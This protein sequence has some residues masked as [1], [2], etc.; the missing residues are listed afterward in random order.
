MLPKGCG[1]V[2]SA[3]AAACPLPGAAL[4]RSGSAAAAR[5]SRAG[6]RQLRCAAMDRQQQMDRAPP[7]GAAQQQV[8]VE[9]HLECFGTGMEVECR[10]VQ[11]GPPHVPVPGEDPAVVSSS[12]SA[13]AAAQ[14]HT[15]EQEKG[16]LEVALDAALLVSPFFFWG[17]SMVAMKQLAPHTTPLLV[18][19]WRL[20]PAGA[21]LLLWARQS[22]RQTPTDPMA[23]VAMALFGLV[24]GACF[25]GF[26]VEGLQRTSA[27]L[28]S[29]IIDSQPLTVALLASLLFGERLGVAG[30]AGLLLASSGGGEAGSMAGAAAV[31]AS[32]SAAAAGSLADAAAAAGSTAAAAAADSG[33][34]AEWS[35]WD[36]GEWWMLLAAQSMAV[37]TV[38]VRWVA[39]YCDPVVATGWHMILG[40]IPLLAL[41]AWQE[42]AEAPARLAQLT[43]SDALLLLY[44]SLLGS[45]ASYG[46]FFY[47]ASRGSLTA[48]SSLTFLTPC[49]AAAGGYLALGETLTPLQLAGAGITLGAVALINNSS[50]KGDSE[51]SGSGGKEAAAASKAE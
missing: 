49:F 29:V 10:I 42:G 12:S 2:T 19:A 15:A 36:S 37:G 25:Q 50:H 31:L 1:R 16:P 48:L 13:A 11:D 28:G 46:V 21:A 38:M 43:G 14:Q 44:I 45:A 27:G 32:S 23:W 4:W 51:D 40:G 34:Q 41:A 7:T 5:P 26:L 17:T 18:A 47:N 35:I 20:I 24:D 6:R 33:S 30:A 8:S 3:V 39:K 9:P 22:G